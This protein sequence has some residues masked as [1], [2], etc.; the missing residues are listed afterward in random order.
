MLPERKGIAASLPGAAPAQLETE[1]ARKLENALAPLQGLKNI[2]TKVQDGA[3]T[4]TAEFRLEKPVQEAVDDVRSAVQGV[5]SD[6]PSD[7]RDPIVKKIDLSGQPVLAYTVRLRMAEFGVVHRYEPSG[8]LHGLLRVRAFTQDDAHIFC[9]ED[10]IVQEVQDFCALADRVYK[11][12]GFT[13]SIKLALRPDKRFGSD[14]MWDQAEAELRDAVVAS[15]VSASEWAS[16]FD[17]VNVCFSKGLGAPVGSALCGSRELI[18]EVLYVGQPAVVLRQRLEPGEVR[19]QR[20]LAED[21]PLGG[22][23]L[24]EYEREQHGRLSSNG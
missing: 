19:H 16:H 6:L 23:E 9:R 7:L 3:V 10:Q 1:V 20:R 4:V 21:G 24:G 17:T 14:A 8:A 5:R 15:G 12:F 11:D 13:Y 2:T 22:G 18:A